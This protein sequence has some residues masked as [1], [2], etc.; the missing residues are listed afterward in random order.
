MCEY[1][2]KK[3]M[4]ITTDDVHLHITYSPLYQDDADEEEE[5]A[6]N[7]QHQQQTECKTQDDNSFQTK[8]E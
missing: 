7:L 2:C 5:A 6:K 3:G 8:E 1:D 4:S